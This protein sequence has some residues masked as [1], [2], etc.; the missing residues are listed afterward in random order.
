MAQY[1][2]K[3]E[4]QNYKDDPT[5]RV[6]LV[7]TVEPEKHYQGSQYYFTLNVRLAQNL[8]IKKS[9]WY[10]IADEVID[11]QERPK[12][13]WKIKKL[14][15]KAKVAPT[16]TV[17]KDGEEVSLYDEM[18]LAGA[19]LKALVYRN[20]DSGYL[21]VFDFLSDDADPQ[22][23]AAMFNRF[24]KFYTRKFSNKP[25]ETETTPGKVATPAKKAERVTVTGTTPVKDE[26]HTEPNEEKES[27]GF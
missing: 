3:D 26:P 9:Q 8:I 24:N 25:A 15:E 10:R 12:D 21:D 13:T 11:G 18:D 17:E 7:Q 20:P 4:G 16:E 22:A 19:T 27:V 23:E 6:V 14:F 2:S 1:V 5:F